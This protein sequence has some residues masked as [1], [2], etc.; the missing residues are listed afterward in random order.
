MKRLVIAV[1]VMMTIVWSS[2]SLA[3]PKAGV[4][5]LRRD[6]GGVRATA[7]F[8][9]NRQTGISSGRITT[10]NERSPDIQIDENT[11]IQLSLPL[12]EPHPC[13]LPKRGPLD[14]GPV[15]FPTQCGDFDG[16]NKKKTKARPTPEQLAAAAA[17]RAIALAPRPRLRMAPSAVG[18]TGLP[19][20]FWVRPRPQPIR[21]VAEVPGLRVEAEARPVQYVWDFG[22]GA[23]RVTTYPGRPWRRQRP[24]NIAH[25][26][27]R[28]DR[29][30]VSVEVI[31]EARWRIGAGP[32]RHLG[33]FSNSDADD[34]PV[35][36]VVAVLARVR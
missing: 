27:E 30:E 12:F 34:Y 35:R 3:A 6:V 25:T 29:Y 28:R 13:E 5:V 20:Y 32:W 7:H 31:W 2:E 36:Q 21:A 19:S 16:P 22:D 17:D 14:L 15:D 9:S 24:G 26:Y 23:E 11:E 8:Y 33:F 4:S 18:L 10:V 1:V